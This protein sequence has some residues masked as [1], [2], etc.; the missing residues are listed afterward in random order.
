M[1]IDI[2][3]PDQWRDFFMMV[4]AV[5]ATLTGL[6]FVALSHNL[7]IITKDLTHRYRAIGA[8]TNLTA[9]FMRCALVSMGEQSH[10]A[11]GAE[12]LI[13]SGI[14]GAIFINGYLRAARSGKDTSPPSIFRTVGGS[15]CYVIEMIGATIFI[16]GSLWGLYTAAVA[17]VA[18]F[19][20]VITGAWLLVVGL[21]KE[22]NTLL[23]ARG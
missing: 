13:V 22:K 6:I 16:F 21:P 10:Q 17:M 7:K 14:A 4:G 11:V 3:R 2:Y 19:Y 12:L 9:V 8:I 18:S 1:A 23:K 20:F 5:A 15:L